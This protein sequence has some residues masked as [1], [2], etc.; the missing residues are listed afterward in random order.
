MF[1]HYQ[2]SGFILEKKDIREADR[3]FTFYTNEF[4][5]L[6]FLAKGARKIKSK[7]RGGLKLFAFSEIEF[8]Q[9]KGYK[10]LTDSVIK[11]EFVRISSSLIKLKIAHKIAEVLNNL[12]KEED[13]DKKIWELLKNT[14][15]ELNNCQPKAGICRLIYYYYFWNL[16]DFIGVKPS[17]YNC[18]LCQKK[19]SLPP[20]YFSSNQGGILCKKCF[21][22]TKEGASIN[23]ET[24]K[25]LRLILKRDWSFLLKVKLNQ[26]H[27]RSLKIVTDSYYF[28]LLQELSTME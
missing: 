2:S 7:L 21:D 19:L 20:F 8:I 16:I 24:I 5:K 27:L 14:L 10:T 11:S 1:I 25:I 23:L 18:V 26:E 15:E 28:Y 17:I 3:I 13:P 4:G 9:G 22:N 12:T 6:R